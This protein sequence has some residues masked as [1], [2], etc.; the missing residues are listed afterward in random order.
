MSR[1]LKSI[2][3]STKC[4]FVWAVLLAFN[5]HPGCLNF[6]CQPSDPACNPAGSLL[7]IRP[8]MGTPRWVVV[9]QGGSIAHSAD[10]ISWTDVTVAGGDLRA[11]A[12]GPAGFVAVGEAGRVLVSETGLAGTWVEQT[13]PT[14][15]DLKGVAYGAGQYV[16]VGGTAS[17]IILSSEDGQSWVDRSIALGQRLED[18]AFLN[19]AFYAVGY[20]VRASSADGVSWVNN[21]SAG[22]WQF[23]AFGNGLFMIAN[24]A[25]IHT[26]PDFAVAMPVAGTH[27]SASVP[28]G[29]YVPSRSAFYL[30]GDDGPVW[31]TSTGAAPSASNAFSV[32][33][34]N[35]L[36]S[37]GDRILVASDAGELSYSDELNSFTL[38]SFGSDS[39]FGAVYAE[40]PN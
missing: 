22:D 10:A 32:Q 18:V 12:Y 14:A 2:A 23:V 36:A 3:R 28:A 25:N 31:Q 34:H 1:K 39:W 21:N 16:A 13:P 19:G 4:S 40:V 37:D 35:A 24:D 33:T 9:G 8:V 17:D 30:G 26:D 6:E 15:I 5:L 20:N 29:L 11:V 38:N 27:S 7:Y